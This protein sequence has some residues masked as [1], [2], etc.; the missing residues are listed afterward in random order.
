MALQIKY[1]FAL[2]RKCALMH[3]VA[4]LCKFLRHRLRGEWWH[5]IAR[6]YRI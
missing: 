5:V 4:N 2:S 3:P 6:E 1:S